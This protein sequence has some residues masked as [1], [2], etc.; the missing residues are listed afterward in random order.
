MGY[1][2]ELHE[3]VTSICSPID[4]YAK[5]YR[6]FYEL[7]PEQ[8]AEE[9]FQRRRRDVDE[10]LPAVVGAQKLSVRSNLE[11]AVSVL[12]YSMGRGGRIG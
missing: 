5:Y 8:F 10:V 4:P 12:G 2:Q 11:V 7:S 6:K 3:A 9:L 1:L